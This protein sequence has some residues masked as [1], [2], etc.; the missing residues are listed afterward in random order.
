MFSNR[1]NIR[2]PLP[3]TLLWIF[4]CKTSPLFSHVSNN[5]VSV[6]NLMLVLYACTNI[7]RRDVGQVIVNL[8]GKA[9]YINIHYVISFKVLSFWEGEFLVF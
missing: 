9:K 5:F 1:K 7:E 2:N 8:Q 6:S 3:A 4:I